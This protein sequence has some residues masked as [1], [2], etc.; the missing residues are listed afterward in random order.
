MK[1]IFTLLI[2]ILLLS[3][4]GKSE[5]DKVL[6]EFKSDVSSSK[7]YTLNGSLEIYNDEDTFTYSLNVGYKKKD[8]YKVT[9]VNQTNN[10][11]QIILKNNDGVY[12]IT[13]SLNKSFKF[14]SEWPNNSS[15]AYLLESIQNDLSTTENK[16]FSKTDDYYIFKSL[17]NYP[18]NPDLTYQK[19]YFDHD[20]ELKKVEVYNTN[21]QIR[22]KVLIN[23]IDYKANL[24]DNYF[25]IESSI[26]E[27]CCNVTDE[28]SN[29][30]E[31]LYPLYIPSDTYLSA[32]ETVATD[33]G[34][35]AILTFSGSK[36]FVLV[37]EAAIAGSEF[38]IVPVYGDPLM[39][40]GTVGALS[41]NSLY[42][43]FN[44]VSYYLAGSNLSTEEL[45]NVA[46]SIS[47]TIVTG[48]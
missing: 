6:N 5:E 22:I 24:D 43:T 28:T 36:D 15:Q 40:N 21:D 42:W 39:M 25:T 31:I 4:C 14:Q 7:S 27:N 38:E 20:I 41:G 16:E 3:G 45:L 19:L 9:L 44:D 46:N 30:N 37:E 8:M 23:S 32:K 17:V 12:V 10:H 18:N 48:K 47:N 33:N 26:D 11:E 29:F 13:P 35:R 2:T 34:N 1:K